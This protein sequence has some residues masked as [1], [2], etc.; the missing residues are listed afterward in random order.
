M[1]ESFEIYAWNIDGS[2]VEGFP[3][4][5]CGVVKAAPAIGDLDN[6]VVFTG[7]NAPKVKAIIPVKQLI[8]ELIDEAAKELS[9]S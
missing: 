3:F 9:R 7:A 1:P 5:T 6:A 8:D 4:E 2:V